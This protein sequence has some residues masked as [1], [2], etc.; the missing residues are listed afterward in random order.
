KIEKELNLLNYLIGKENIEEEF[1]SLVEEYPKV[2]KILPILIAIRDDKLS[3]TP[4]ITDME[5]LIPQNKRYIFNDEINE[6]IKKELLLFFR[7]TGLKDFFE[8]KAVKNLVD[9]CVGVEVG[10]DTNARKNRTG[11]LM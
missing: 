3:S 7:E 10:F 1:L 11:T 2:R 6:D 5:S 4:I 9:Y 8:N